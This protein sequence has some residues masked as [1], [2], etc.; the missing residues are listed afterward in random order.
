MSLSSKE[1]GKLGET[2]ALQYLK[3][4]GYLIKELNYTFLKGEID[5]IALDDEEIVFVE[6]KSRA[7]LELGD[8]VYGVTPAKVK[9]I[10]KVAEFYLYDKNIDG[11]YCRF[12]VVT[13]LFLD[14]HKPII[15]HYINAFD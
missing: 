9:Q 15:E 5:I 14:F 3:E 12:D 2:V 1:L 13:V 11:V 4:K 8:P 6:V 7:N 10:K